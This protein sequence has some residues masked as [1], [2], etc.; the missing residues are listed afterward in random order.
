MEIIPTPALA[1]EW[2]QGPLIDDDDD[3]SGRLK[4]LVAP[5]ASRGL[6]GERTGGGVH[7]GGGR[8]DCF[9]WGGSAREGGFVCPVIS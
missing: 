7:A 6:A 9:F 3:K 2:V 1:I 5:G 4:K 8:R